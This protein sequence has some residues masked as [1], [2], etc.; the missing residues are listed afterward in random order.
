MT[1]SC[2]KT[3]KGDSVSGRPR[4]NRLE[5]SAAER[6][7]LE[8][9]CQDPGMHPRKKLGAQILLY[10]LDGLTTAEIAAR[11]GVSQSFAASLVRRAPLMGLPETVEAMPLCRHPARITASGAEWVCSLARKCSSDSGI[12]STPEWSMESLAGYI[13]SHC[14][15]AGYPELRKIVKSTVWR[16]IRSERQGA[17]HEASAQDRNKKS[18]AESGA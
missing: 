5:A 16:I 18:P 9:I 8:H 3:A 12:M 1:L 13:R 2:R 14:E 4:K 11:T 6:Q 10:A 7:A 15:E 17:S